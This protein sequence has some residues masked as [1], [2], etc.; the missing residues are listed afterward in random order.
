MTAATPVGLRNIPL[1]DLKAQHRSI[2]DQVLAEVTRVIDSQKFIMGD[3]VKSLESEIADY[4]STKHAIGCAS[5][6]DALLLA[7]MALEIGPG[8]KVITTPYT[9]FATVG[10]ICRLGATPV[11]ADIERDTF[12]LDV[13]KVGEALA[14]HPEVRAIIP[15][16]LFGAC[17]DMAPLCS[18]AE[19]KGIFVIEDAAQSI[20]SEYNGHRAGSLGHIGCFSFFP[21]KN[22]GAYGD[23]GMLATN[24]DA[25]AEKL[26]AL[27]V[28]G[29]RRKYYH[30][31]VGVNSRLDALQAAVL[32]I[33]LR[34]LD[35]WTE[36]R[37]RNANLYRQIIR[38]LRIPVAVPVEKPYQSR[39]IYNQFVIVGERRNQLQA[40]LK[41]HGIGTEVYYPLP[42]H[43]QTCFLHLGYQVGDFPVS[44][45]LAN[46]SL[47]LPVYPELEPEDIEYV[48]HT[49]KHFYC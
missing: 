29:T 11:F 28:H 3:D 41:E 9:F 25:L 7:L 38:N 37:Q 17:V 46:E 1:L 49:L 20:G 18:L 12:N 31:W 21:S 23:G 48:C 6:S 43:M 22:L 33:K 13:A 19:Q 42:M 8:D 15:V 44:E 16:H 5:G 10:A 36:G 40:Y 35:G 27:R 45:R 30:D 34:H 14:K 47:A 26:K 32:R 2:R 24:D 4:C 39:H